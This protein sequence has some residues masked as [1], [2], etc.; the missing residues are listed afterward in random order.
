MLIEVYRAG[1]K[2]W[3][4]EYSQQAVETAMQYPNLDSIAAQTVNRLGLVLRK[5]VEEA[6]ND[7]D[8]TQA[9]RRP[10]S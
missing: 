10:G 9:I 4:K 8:F 1:S 5:I 2:A 6:V 3:D 7:P